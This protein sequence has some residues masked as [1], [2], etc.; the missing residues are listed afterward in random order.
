MTRTWLFTAALTLTLAAPV[1]AKEAASPI[2]TNGWGDTHWGMSV[3]DVIAEL[4]DNG[5]RTDLD[6]KTKMV[7]GHPTG[8]E[9]SAKLFGHRYDLSYHFTPDTQQLSIVKIVAEEPGACTALEAH[10]VKHLGEGKPE[11]E[12]METGPKQALILSQRKWQTAQNGNRYSYTHVGAEGAD[13]TY[14]HI[15]IEDASIKFKK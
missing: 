2:G 3:R 8:A 11:R 9:D 12:R 5:R 4:S 7:W 14:C 15:A 13:L 10:F 1:A 6:D